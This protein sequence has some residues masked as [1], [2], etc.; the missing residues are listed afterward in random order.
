MGAGKIINIFPE[1]LEPRIRK[2]NKDVL[3]L[4]LSLLHVSTPLDRLG[5]RVT[6]IDQRIRPRWTEE[7]EEELRE[8]KPICMGITSMTGWQI[9]GGIE[10]A[11]I[12]RSRYPNVPIVWGGVHPTLTSP[13]ILDD[14][15]V[16]IVVIG[17]GE[18]SYAEIVQAIQAGD[19][20]E[21]IEGIAFKDNGRVTVSPPRAPARMDDLPDPAFHLFN[22]DEYIIQNELT[23]RRSLPI[24]TSKGC[25]HSCGYCYNSEFNKMKYRAMSPERVVLDIRKMMK[26]FRLNGLYLLDDNFFQNRKRTVQIFE[27]IVRENL[28]LVLYNANCRVD[29]VAA[30]PLEYLDLMKRAGIRELRLGIESG[31]DK[32]QKEIFKYTTYEQALEANRKMKEVGIRPV[33]NFMIGFPSEGEDDIRMTLKLMSTLLHEN[34]ESVVA[35][36][37]IFTPYPGTPLFDVSRELGWEAPSTLRDWQLYDWGHASSPHQDRRHRVLLHNASFVSRHLDPRFAKNRFHGL[38]ASLMRAIL[39]RGS[40]GFLKST[41][42]FPS[43]RTILKKGK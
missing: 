27:Q 32:V 22:M 16:D 5:Y 7:L 34:P 42:L 37:S 10:A 15:L 31:S 26:D 33:Y 13:Q 43:S 25:G 1:I 39:R 8:E 18:V 14:D 3:I 6:V 19:S 17:E 38:Y 30:Y 36:C 28:D 29:Y 4:P 23:E 41:L 12:L 2:Q 9:R 35:G 40:I 11:S 21:K 24:L 20:L